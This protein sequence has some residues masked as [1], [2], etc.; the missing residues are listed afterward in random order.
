MEADHKHNWDYEGV[1]LDCHESLTRLYEEAEKQR[2]LLR[3]RRDYWLSNSR[4]D[5]AAE[6]QECIDRLPNVRWTTSEILVL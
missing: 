6:I 1:C 3:R 4:P 2:E 5:I